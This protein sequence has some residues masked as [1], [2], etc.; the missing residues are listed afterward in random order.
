MPTT[1]LIPTQPHSPTVPAV[2]TPSHEPASSAPQTLSPAPAAVVSPQ[3]SLGG[4]ATADATGGTVRRP[5]LVT[6]PTAPTPETTHTPSNHHTTITTTRVPSRSRRPLNEGCRVAGESVR[7]N[8]SRTRDPYT[9]RPTRI[10]A[11]S[12]RLSHLDSS[13][14]GTLGGCGSECWAGMVAMWCWCAGAGNGGGVTLGVAF[15]A[16]LP[17]AGSH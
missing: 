14:G 5:R 12:I 10:R 9:S 3:D 6:I 2:T 17:S 7:S 1:L 8:S 15:S 13:C 11:D 16:S 4:R